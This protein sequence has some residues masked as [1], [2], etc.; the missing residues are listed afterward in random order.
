MGVEGDN[1]RRAPERAASR[2]KDL[3]DEATTVWGKADLFEGV[4]TEEE[5]DDLFG[6][7]G[8]SGNE[9][10]VLAR[11]E[12]VTGPVRLDDDFLLRDDRRPP[13]AEEQQEQPA[14]SEEEAAATVEMTADQAAQLVAEASA[15]A[16]ARE[17]G[18]PEADLPPPSGEFSAPHLPADH[19]VLSE[20][21]VEVSG[22]EGIAAEAEAEARARE[23]EADPTRVVKPSPALSHDCRM[24]GKKTMAPK[25]RRFRGSKSGAQGFRCDRCGNTFCAAHV[26]R[27][28]SLLS[29][30]FG[31]GVFRCQLCNLDDSPDH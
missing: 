14:E 11:H 3:E 16:E 28:S 10:G 25:P 18:E 12:P 20:P 9:R 22:D 2:R 15:E 31:H 19:A 29:S 8:D 5:D 24:C 1:T 6:E 30:L 27:V 13:D 4:E 7:S 26:V 23:L 21:L 17:R